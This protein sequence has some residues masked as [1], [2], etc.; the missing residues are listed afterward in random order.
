MTCLCTCLL[1]DRSQFQNVSQEAILMGLTTFSRVLSRK[2]KK[3]CTWTLLCEG[4]WLG[5]MVETASLVATYDPCKLRGKKGDELLECLFWV[6]QGK[7]ETGRN[8]YYFFILETGLLAVSTLMCVWVL[9]NSPRIP[10]CFAAAWEDSWDM[11]GCKGSSPV[12][13]IAC[14]DETG[15]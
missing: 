6:T 15:L 12:H 1:R 10:R 2:W 4:W 7:T 5:S 11:E 9:A 3:K 14:Y 13:K 8:T